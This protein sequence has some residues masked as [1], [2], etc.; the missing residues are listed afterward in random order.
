MFETSTTRNMTS[1]IMVF[2]RLFRSF[3]TEGSHIYRNNCPA[4]TIL[5]SRALP[6]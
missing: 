3:N 2:I 6:D 5:T 4:S 1:H